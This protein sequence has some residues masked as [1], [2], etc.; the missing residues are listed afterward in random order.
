VTGLGAAGYHTVED[1]ANEKDITK[2]GDVPGIGIKKARQL[3]SAAEA[4]LLDEQKLRAE[5]NAER[6]AAS[7][8]VVATPEAR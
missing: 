4:Y 6:A 5:L 2:L 1:I 7:G 8:S 3:K